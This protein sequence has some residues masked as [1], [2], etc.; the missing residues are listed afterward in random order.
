VDFPAFIRR[1][2]PV[3]ESRLG[4]SAS[5]AGYSGELKISFYK[6]GL[7]LKFEQGRL[8]EIE[9]WKPSPHGHSGEAA[10]PGLTFTQLLFGY[11]TFQELQ[12]AFPD[13]LANN[14]P[15]S[16]LLEVLFP[17]QASDVWPV[18]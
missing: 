5:F 13:C 12:Y 11:R 7:Q 10:F 14:D 15:A 18:S 2:A 4:A 9:N 6:T 8:S 3:L 1:I 16:A 17:K